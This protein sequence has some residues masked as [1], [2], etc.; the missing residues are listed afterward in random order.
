MKVIKKG[1]KQK[2]WAKEFK[3]TN[4]GNG[5]CGCGALLLVEENDILYTGSRHSYG[6]TYPEYYYGFQCP[7][8]NSITDFKISDNIP[9]R[10]TSKLEKIVNPSIKDKIL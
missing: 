10:I 6:D 1:R 7:E 3:C 4:H 2:G 5:N 9:I 8:C